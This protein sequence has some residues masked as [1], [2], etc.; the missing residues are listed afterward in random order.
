MVVT[1]AREPSSTEPMILRMSSVERRVRSA[2]SRISSATT[3]NPRPCSPACAAMMAA[4]SASRFVRSVISS[5]TPMMPATLA[6]SPCNCASACEARSVVS[7]EEWMPPRV[8]S[9]MRAPL[10]G[11]AG[12][13]LGQRAD[14]LGQP[15]DGVDAL[16]QLLRGA[17]G[18]LGELRLFARAVEQR[19]AAVGEDAHPFRDGGAALAD[20]AVLRLQRHGHLVERL[21]EAA[22]VIARLVGDAEGEIA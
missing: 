10:G 3:V 14:F 5:I 20:G 8:A 21:A 13:I 4:F 11:A 12:A 6:K 1:A 22:D 9:T 15:D 16:A 2:S 7:R 19:F 17:G 18:V